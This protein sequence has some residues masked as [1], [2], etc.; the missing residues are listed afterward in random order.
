VERDSVR[1]LQR[2]PSAFRSAVEVVQQRAVP[3]LA[4][5]RPGQ[6]Q[7]VGCRGAARSTLPATIAPV[8]QNAPAHGM[9]GD[10]F[11]LPVLVPFSNLRPRVPGRVRS[12]MRPSSPPCTTLRPADP[13][14]PQGAWAFA[15][16]DVHRKELTTWRWKDFLALPRPRHGRLHCVTKWSSSVRNGR[17]VTI[18][19][20]L[21]A[22]GLEPPTRYV[23]R[24]ATVGTRRNCLEDL[25]GGPRTGRLR[26]RWRRRSSRSTGPAR[27]LC[28]TC[29]L[30]VRE[31]GARLPHGEE[32][33]RLLGTRGYISAR[34]L[35]KRNATQETELA[36]IAHPWLR[37]GRRDRAGNARVKTIA[38]PSRW[39][40]TC[41]PARRRTAHGGG[42]IPAQ[43]SYSI[44]SPPEEDGVELTVEHPRTARSRR[45]LNRRVAGG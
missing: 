8:L 36:S 39:R 14:T 17:G 7:I 12:F 24:S 22:A 5:V 18:G 16:R 40:D 1:P 30:E 4:E 19:A 42:W 27:L 11:P 29:I 41:R 34:S 3:E 25:L 33:A 32:R 28:H 45:S 43:R 20:L 9:H 44:A 31:V 38:S 26:V 15:L 21:E 35:G 13:R 10:C 37:G 6:I 2:H 23:R